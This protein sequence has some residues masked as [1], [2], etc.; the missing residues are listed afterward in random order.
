MTISV[1]QSLLHQTTSTIKL[2]QGDTKPPLITSLSS[3]NINTTTG[4]L[5]TIPLDIS[6]STVILKLRQASNTANIIDIVDGALLI[7]YQL[8][9][10]YV[11]SSPPYDVPGKG[12]RVIF[13]WNENSLSV[14]G[15]IQ[16][17]IEVTYSDQT[18]Q[19]VYDIIK[20]KVRE[21]F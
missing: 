19:S 8:A 15:D 7:G 18:V 20:F 2:V 16:G 17:E 12:G 13:N 21:Q 9:N 10:G 11:I 14:P 5:E 4:V 1:D 3:Q 6:G